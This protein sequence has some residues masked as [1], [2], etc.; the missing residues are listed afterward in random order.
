MNA[1][2]GLCVITAAC[3]LSVAAHVLLV[4]RMS[5]VFD[6]HIRWMKINFEDYVKHAPTCESMLKRWWVWD[7]DKF[8]VPPRIE[9]ISKSM[10]GVKL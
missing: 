4:A 3:V 9:E 7:A 2:V 10:W 5:W 8:Y 1:D 6:T